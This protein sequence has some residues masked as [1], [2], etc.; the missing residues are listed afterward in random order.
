MRPNLP[1]VAATLATR[2]WYR[3]RRSALG[4]DPTDAELCFFIHGR[5][6]YLGPE[7]RDYV[8]TC[9]IQHPPKYIGKDP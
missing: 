3:Q 2:E 7:D 6:G 8:Y 4:R 9:A 5:Y 1:T